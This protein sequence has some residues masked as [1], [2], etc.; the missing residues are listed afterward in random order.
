MKSVFGMVA[1]L[2]ALAIVS[3]VVKVQMTPSKSSVAPAAAT[4]GLSIKTTEGA[5]TAHES[6]QIQQQLRDKVNAAMQAAPKP[7]V[8][9]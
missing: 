6:Q 2:I 4:A 9:K 5:T 7:E 3:M 8:D 1:I